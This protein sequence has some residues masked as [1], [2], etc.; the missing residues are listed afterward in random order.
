M[1]EMVIAIGCRG[2]AC[3]LHGKVTFKMACFDTKNK[4]QHE[5]LQRGTDEDDDDSEKARKEKGETARIETPQQRTN[6]FKYQ[7]GA[8]MP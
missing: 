7:V 3:V 5:G 1:Q 8:T 2:L 4:L 6:E